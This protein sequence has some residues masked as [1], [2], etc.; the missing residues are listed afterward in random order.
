[1]RDQNRPRTRTVY[2]TRTVNGYCVALLGWVTIGIVAAIS[3]GIAYVAHGAFGDY[4]LLVA[5]VIT[6]IASIFFFRGAMGMFD[7]P[8]PICGQFFSFVASVGAIWY[9]GAPVFRSLLDAWAPT[10]N[11]WLANF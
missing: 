8:A 2:Q 11:G 10:I 7:Y 9:T 6:P 1:M 4:G 5:L 3:I